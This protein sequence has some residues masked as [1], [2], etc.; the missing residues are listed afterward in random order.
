MRERKKAENKTTVERCS[1]CDGIHIDD[2]RS[3]VNMNN[4]VS[5]YIERVNEVLVALLKIQFQMFHPASLPSS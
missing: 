2:R 5:A 3:K 4:F 1:G